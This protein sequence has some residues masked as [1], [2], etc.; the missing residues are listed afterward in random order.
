MPV[1]KQKIIFLFSL[2]IMAMQ[3]P[4]FLAQTQE[5][6]LKAAFLE[7]FTLFV[8]WPENSEFAETQSP[9]I[10]ATIGNNPFGSEL[11][12]LYNVH[13]IK[14][15]KVEIIHLN[16]SKTI[17]H[18][19]ILFVS[20]SMKDNLSTLLAATKNKPILLIGDSPGYAEK[21]VHINFF[22]EDN[23]VRFEINE[24]EVRLSGLKMSH[25]LLGYAKLVEST[26]KL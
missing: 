2:L 22:M 11:E 20:E 3:L 21:G 18:C 25:L 26:G 1:N 15:K 19:H 8:E 7:K 17:P 5:Y 4:A 23:R 16:K 9:F 13:K 12:N 10:I 14:N 6:T 24:S